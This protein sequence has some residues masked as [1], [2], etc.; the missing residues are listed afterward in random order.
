MALMFKESDFVPLTERYSMAKPFQTQRG[1][2]QTALGVEPVGWTFP[3][4][5]TA[6][7]LAGCLDT[8]IARARTYEASLARLPRVSR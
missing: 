4:Y 7:T 1:Q 6:P 5:V 2:W 3:L 8:V